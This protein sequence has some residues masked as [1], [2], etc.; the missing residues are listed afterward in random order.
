[1]SLGRLGE[2]K[3][4]VRWG[5]EGEKLRL[6]PSVAANISHLVIG[7][8]VQAPNTQL[9][10]SRDYAK[11]CT[12]LLYLHKVSELPHRSRPLYSSCP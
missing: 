6:S 1:M 2:R 12:A 4:A 10:I 7:H 9:I 5:D 11:P 8:P 3:A